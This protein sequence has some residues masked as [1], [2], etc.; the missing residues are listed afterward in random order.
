M[1]LGQILDI[2]ILLAVLLFSASVHEVSHGWFAYRYGDPTAHSLGRLSL[3]PIRHIDPMMSIIVPIIFYV[4]T[5]F[6]FGGAKPV[7]VQPMYL[8][9]PRK[10]MLVISAAGPASNAII[11]LIATVIFHI[12][13]FL[14]HIPFIPDLITSTVLY[15]AAVFVQINIIL[16]FFNLMPIPPLDGFG[17]LSNSLPARY[18]SMV[19]SIEQVGMFILLVVLFSGILSYTVFPIIRAVVSFL[20]Q[21]S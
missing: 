19:Q 9:N 18:D 3:N 13:A 4:S 5:S 6:I 17:I 20:L 21:L 16:C 12:F 7:P 11:A 2:I 15:I 1:E 10:N 14:A 8:R